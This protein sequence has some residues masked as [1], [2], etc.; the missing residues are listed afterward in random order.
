MVVRKILLFFFLP[1]LWL[2]NV[3][4]NSV[5]W[6]VNNKGGTTPSLT[7]NFR[8]MSCPNLALL[9]RAVPAFS[10]SK[11]VV[12]TISLMALSSAVQR[13]ERSSGTPLA[14]ICYDRVAAWLL[15]L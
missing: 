8:L 7:G 14:C 11:D 2:F 13:L 6:L 15:K 9:S 5:Q 1:L 12:S 4:D 10:F 3:F